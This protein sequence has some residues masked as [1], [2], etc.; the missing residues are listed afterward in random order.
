MSDFS[1]ATAWGGCANWRLV[2]RADSVRKIH[3]GTVPRGGGIAVA[4]SYIATLALSGRTMPAVWSVLP[5]AG[6]IFSGR[7]CG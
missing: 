5:A 1:L 6:L 2:D 7:D 3:E 4:V